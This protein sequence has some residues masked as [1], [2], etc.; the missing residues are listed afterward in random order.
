MKIFNF[1][2]YFVFPCDL[3]HKKPIK[4]KC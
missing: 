1:Q 2:F 4:G 3:R